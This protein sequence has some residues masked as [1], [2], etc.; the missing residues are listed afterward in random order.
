MTSVDEP[1]KVNQYNVEGMLNVLDAA[2]DADIE[3]VVNASS[4]ERLRQARYLPYDEDH[5]TT[6]ISPYG[7]SKLATEQYA[8]VYN[9]AYGLSTVSLRYFTDTVPEYGDHELR[10]AVSPWRTTGRLRQ[11]RADA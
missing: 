4:V 11:R 8:R 10:F 3:R 1:R 6:P 2:R 9:E 5:L 7:A